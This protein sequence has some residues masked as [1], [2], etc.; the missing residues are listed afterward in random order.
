[1]TNYLKRLVDELPRAFEMLGISF[2]NDKTIIVES[3]S[4]KKS[5]M[6]V[7]IVFLLVFNIILSSLTLVTLLNH[8]NNY[9]TI[10]MPQ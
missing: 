9:N 2:E 3:I 4:N 8:I 7:I 10:I 1:M 6:N 5:K